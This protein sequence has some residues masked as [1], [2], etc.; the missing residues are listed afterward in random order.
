MLQLAKQGQRPKYSII[1]LCLLSSHV[2]L[3][4]EHPCQEAVLVAERMADGSIDNEQSR[5]VEASLMTCSSAGVG[6]VVDAVIMTASVAPPSLQAVSQV[7]FITREALRQHHIWSRRTIATRKSHADW[8]GWWRNLSEDTQRRYSS[9]VDSN[10]IATGLLSE[11]PLLRCVFGNP[12]RRRTINPSL[13][14]NSVTKLAAAICNERGS[15]GCRPGRCSRRVW[16]H[17]RGCTLH[18]REPARTRGCHVLDLI[19]G[20]GAGA[21][22]SHLDNAG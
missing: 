8:E 13:L 16:C 17:E 9:R 22:I 3:L 14:S 5:A 20:K 15:S 4:D 12:F 1:C 18:L 6:G 19:L 7:M 10:T 21:P 2:A 11:V